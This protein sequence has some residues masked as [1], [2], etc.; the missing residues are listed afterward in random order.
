M[1]RRALIT[2]ING[3]DGSYLTK[4]LL[5]K[6]YEVVGAVRH[7]SSANFA[8]LREVGVDKDIELVDLEL[9]ESSNITHIFD[10]AQPDEVYNLAAQSFVQL[11]FEEPVYTGQVDAIGV[12]RL[13]ET[14]R[15]KAKHARFYQ[16]STSE[17]FGKVQEVPQRETTPFYPRSPY[18]VAK[19]YAHWITVNYRES[20]GLHCSSGILFNHESPLRGRHFVTRKITLGL[21][22]VK[23][24]KVDK[25][26]LGNLSAERD[27]GFAGDYVEGMWRMVQAEQPD[28]YVLATG[29]RHS[30]RE[31]VAHA[32]AALG[33]DIVFEGSGETER[34]IDRKSGRTV[35]T[36]NPSFYRPAEG[37]LLVGDPAKAE[38]K[39]GWRRT[40]SFQDLVAMMAE[41][42]DR[43]VRNGH[44]AI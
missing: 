29:E 21:A 7:A 25:V 12:T 39:L 14:L 24:G 41:A 11:S 37:D 30:V 27:W 28:D 40:M 44:E 31:F 19:L 22:G 26:E 3:Q 35:V 36:V 9:L 20:Y 5:S 38:Q 33:F 16:A 18:A 2:G 17:L 1:A 32:G 6:G 8:R 10:R 34:G 13:L 23:H 43:R 42:D 15:A 4:L